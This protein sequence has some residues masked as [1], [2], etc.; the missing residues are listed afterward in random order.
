M[1]SRSA[2]PEHREVFLL[3]RTGAQVR[4]ESRWLHPG[5]FVISELGGLLLLCPTVFPESP[6]MGCMAR[7]VPN[8][9]L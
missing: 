5:H 1:G 7:D 4:A 8:I 2:D 6:Y 9:R 3:H